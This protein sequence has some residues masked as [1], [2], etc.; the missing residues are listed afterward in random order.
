MLHGRKKKRVKANN[1]EQTVAQ[2]DTF[3]MR[4][5]KGRQSIVTDASLDSN[6]F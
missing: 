2:K 6:T 1:K 5:A 3:A 4:E